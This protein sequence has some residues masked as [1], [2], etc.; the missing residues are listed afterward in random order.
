MIYN[1]WYFVTKRKNAVWYCSFALFFL[2][3]NNKNMFDL[4]VFKNYFLEIYL[5][6]SVF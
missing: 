4:I 2:N 6:K 1:V 5:K 3:K